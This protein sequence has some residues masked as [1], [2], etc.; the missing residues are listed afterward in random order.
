MAMLIKIFTLYLL[1]FSA[2]FESTSSD[3]QMEL[4]TLRDTYVIPGI[5]AALYRDG[6]LIEYAVS[7]IRKVGSNG[8]SQ[9]KINFI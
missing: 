3:F 2:S 4:D 7:G 6:Q 9:E 5:S 1:I 8:S